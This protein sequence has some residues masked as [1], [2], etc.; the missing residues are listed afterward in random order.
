M[1]LTSN[2]NSG[3]ST[4]FDKIQDVLHKK[5]VRADKDV[6][7]LFT[8]AQITPIGQIQTRATITASGNVGTQVA[9]PAG[10][11]RAANLIDE[12]GVK[13]IGGLSSN[14]SYPRID[15]NTSE[16]VNENEQGTLTGAT[17]EGLSLTPR[18][19]LSY[20]EYSNE[21]V[22]NPNTDVAGAIEEDMIN[23]IWEK[24]QTTMF[25]DIYTDAT[26]TTLANYNDIVAFEL[27][28]SQKKIN[29]GVYV[30]S[31]T[32]AS[33][34]KKMMNGSTPV[35]VN[36]YMNGYRVIET[37]SLDGESI[38]FADWSKLL[39]GQW[40]ALDITVDNVTKSPQGIVKLI[41]NSYWDWGLIDPNGFAFATTASAN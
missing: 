17:F 19:L 18:R 13:Y 31:P 2:Q 37:P 40:G 27:A 36:G 21:V 26:P 25:N 41:I 28:A 34:L 20:V 10:Q 30:V 35:M 3:Q 12:L 29:G 5:E 32:A 16:W 11:Q 8:R 4:L 14:F 24:V 15:N 23:S 39:L 38:I 1:I 33:K 6:K 9:R 7:D 22:L